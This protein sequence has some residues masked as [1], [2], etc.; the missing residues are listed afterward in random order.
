VRFFKIF[1]IIF[2][3]L[4]IVLTI[5]YSARISVINNLVKTHLSLS[6]I[7][8]TCLDISL[9]SNLTLNVDKV[10][11]Q[12]PKADIELVDMA[13]QWQYSSTFEVTDIDV[14]LVNIKGTEHFFSNTNN[15]PQ[16]KKQQN[17]NN[18]SFS[19]LLS[20][21]LPPYAHIITQ[22]KLPVKIN[23]AKIAYLPFTA[24]NKSKKSKEYTQYQRKT[25]YSATVSGADNIFSFTLRDT[26]K[27]EFLKA[28]LTKNEKNFSIALSSE[29]KQ[30]KTFAD[31]HQLPITTE[32]QETINAIDISGNVYLTIEYHNDSLSMKNQISVLKIYAKNGIGSSGEFK[33]LGE[34]DFQS[35]LNLVPE[36]TIDNA[37]NK[38]AN[39][40]NTK[41]ALMFTG[42]NELSLEYNQPQLF[43]ILEENKVSPQIISLLKDNP[44][45]YIKLKAQENT[46]LTFNNKKAL[47]SNV[48]ISTHTDER[49]NLIT[50]NNIAFALPHSNNNHKNNKQARTKAQSLKVQSFIIDSQLFLTQLK[51]FT[52]EPITIHLEGSL[53]KTEKQTN[54]NLAQ[55]SSITT[56]SIVMLKQQNNKSSKNILN[57]ETLTTKIE[58]S[59]QLIEENPLTMNLKVHSQ[60]SQ[61]SIPK[62][63][64]INSFDLFS[65]IKGNLDDIII[66]ASTQADGIDLGSIVI[67]GPILSPKLLVAANKLQLTDLLS[68]N[69]QLPTTIELVNG[70]LDYS[71]SGHLADLNNIEST[72]FDV[73]IAVTSASGEVDG[74]WLQELNWQ[75]HF[76]LLAGKVT[77]KPNAKE[78]LTVDL[79][80][81]PTPVS[82]LSINT[83]WTFN[84]SFKL[85]ASKLKADILGGSFSIPKLQWPIEHGHS[86]NVQL[87]SIDLEQVLALDKKQGIVVTGNI[88][89]ELPVTYDGEKFIIEDGKLHNISNGLIQVMDNPAVAELKA[90]NS[91][92]QLAFDAL[93]NLHYHQ[94]SSAVSMSDDGYMQLDT[95]I[96]GRN[97]DIDNDVNLNLNLSYDLLGLLESMSIT[98]RFEKSIIEG[99]Q[100]NKE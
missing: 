12:N 10:C 15:A 19:Q 31:I 4:L 26:E 24:I 98:Q 46:T 62:A 30:L 14:Q 69:I 32:M 53:K 17:S 77:T 86:V 50:L 20:T 25:P 95:V 3:T 67:T 80:E 28:K 64:Q 84:K 8:V 35:Q 56:N 91:Q 5:T 88:S 74:I 96:K 38:L 63:L 99:L 33:L 78:N 39:E 68:L 72:P 54:L 73:S 37:K 81:A 52:T 94:L 22:F 44:F 83:S 58:G 61:F 29:L 85:S 21:T 51:E 7:E 76:T 92:L 27:V 100:K 65:T 11:L 42:T 59:V 93:Q 57:L 48:E 75:Q 34:I 41:I 90:N 2:T 97:P 43:A 47:L 49:S 82:K 9:A 89:G 36:K 1:L 6:Q 87:N 13:I 55:N 71:L 66:N 40:G 23:I 60:A 45:E 79:I 70:E 16:S 18:Q